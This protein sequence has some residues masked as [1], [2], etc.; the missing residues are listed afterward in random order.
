M[1]ANNELEEN[2]EQVGRQICIP[3]FLA[4]SQVDDDDDAGLK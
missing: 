2:R 1:R 3:A 4:R